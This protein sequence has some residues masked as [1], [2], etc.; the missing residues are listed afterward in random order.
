MIQ[1]GEK[2]C[3]IFSL[4]LV[5]LKKGG[6]EKRVLRRIFEPKRDEVA[7]GWRRLTTTRTASQLVHFI[8]HCQGDHIKEDWGIK[9]EFKILVRKPEGK[10][11]CGR[12]GCRWEDNIQMDLTETGWK[13]VDLIYLA[14]DGDQW[15]VLM[16]TVMNLQVR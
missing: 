16:D 12:P 13:G 9:N 6:F 14:Q 11:P 10:R 3:I 15:Q 5:Y 2:H 7:R 8:K 1:S 4:N